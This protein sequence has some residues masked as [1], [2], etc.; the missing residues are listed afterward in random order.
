M[1]RGSPVS[2]KEKD[3]ENFVPVHPSHRGTYYKRKQKKKKKKKKVRVF[4]ESIPKGAVG[5]YAQDK[6]RDDPPEVEDY[7]EEW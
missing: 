1:S 6:E 3:P 7:G 4:R 5:F 2:D